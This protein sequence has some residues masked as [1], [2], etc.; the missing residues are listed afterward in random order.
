MAEDH[1]PSFTWRRS[2]RANMEPLI[3]WRQKDMFIHFPTRATE[4]SLDFERREAAWILMQHTET[5]KYWPDLLIWQEARWEYTVWWQWG[6]DQPELLL[7]HQATITR[8]TS[9]PLSKHWR[10]NHVRCLRASHSLVTFIVE[11]EGMQH[12]RAGRQVQYPS[13]SFDF[14]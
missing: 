7:T 11:G 5:T 4:V 6:F 10:A 12:F 1:D 14:E 8:S 2:A 3:A 9:R 13:P